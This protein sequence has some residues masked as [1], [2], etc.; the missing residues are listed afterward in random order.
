VW[1]MQACEVLP[2]P[3]ATFGVVCADASPRSKLEHVAC[4]FKP[5]N[6]TPRYHTAV[7][8]PVIET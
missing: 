2:L 6:L 5:R 1:L 4:C 7:G 3:I 8:P